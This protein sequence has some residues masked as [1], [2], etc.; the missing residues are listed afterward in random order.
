MTLKSQRHD[1]QPPLPRNAVRSKCTQK[2]R[3]TNDDKGEG[4]GKACYNS[5]SSGASP[6]SDILLTA[7]ADAECACAWNRACSSTTLIGLWRS[8]NAKLKKP[9]PR[10]PPV[11]LLRELAVA[12]G[13][14]AAERVPD[15]AEKN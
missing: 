14:L 10:P 2:R 15:M 4:E 13:L 8:D 11:E 7:S 12:D 5:S 9:R 3:D 6:P 1:C